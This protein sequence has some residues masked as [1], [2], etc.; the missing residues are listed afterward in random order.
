MICCFYA[1][2]MFQRWK[3]VFHSNVASISI[4]STVQKD[5]VAYKKNPTDAPQIFYN[6]FD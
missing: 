3:K 5:S 6:T 1:F 4:V 2:H